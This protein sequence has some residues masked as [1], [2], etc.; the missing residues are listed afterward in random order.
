MSWFCGS[1]RGSKNPHVAHYLD[2]LKG[3]GHHLEDLAKDNFFKILGGMVDKLKESK[4]EDE[5][6]VILNS[7]KWKFLA[8]D[9]NS[10]Y[11]LKI[12]RVLHEGDGHKDHKLKKSWGRPL[13]QEVVGCEKDKKLTKEVVDLFEQVFLLTVG[14]IIKPDTGGLMKLKQRG[15]S[16]P[17]LEKAQSVLDENVSEL[18]IEQAFRVM[19][20][21]FERYIKIMKRFKGVDWTIYVKMRN[22]ERKNNDKKDYDDESLLD[23]MEE[24]LP[25]D[26]EEEEAVPE[27]T[28]AAAAEPVAADSE[29]KKEEQRAE[30][31][32]TEVIDGEG[33][34]E[35]DKKEEVEEDIEEKEKQEAI[36][37]QE[38]RA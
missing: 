8:R 25:T 5:I 17:T 38:E 3:C 34:K 7:L 18:L 14:R 31:E 37:K 20:Q 26:A 9:H 10:L 24:L 29:E 28:E 22:K 33:K 19:F 32:S 1:L 6:K 21:E 16:V 2:D 30:G 23:E 35:E 27:A 11:N 4:D 12:F 13:K 15:T 36:K